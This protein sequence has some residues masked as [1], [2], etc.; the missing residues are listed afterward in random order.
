MPFF[1]DADPVGPKDSEPPDENMNVLEETILSTQDVPAPSGDLKADDDAGSS[2][3]SEHSPTVS[4]RMELIE[5]IKRGESPTWA[6]QGT[7]E[8]YYRDSPRPDKP[9]EAQE[10]SNETKTPPTDAGQQETMPPASPSEI[11][12]PRSAMH[13]GDFFTQQALPRQRPSC[14]T[15][16]SVE[17]NPPIRA[18]PEYPVWPTIPL[19]R[20]NFAQETPH[21]QEQSSRPDSSFP[22]ES[23]V[24]TSLECDQPATPLPFEASFLPVERSADHVP[25][26]HPPPP[27]TP[28]S[29]RRHTLPQQA[30][31]ALRS[32]PPAHLPTLAATEHQSPSLRAGNMP[33]QGHQARRSF[34]SHTP[35]FGQGTSPPFGSM[36]SRRPSLSSESPSLH[37]A[38][39]VGSY[40]ESIL[41]GRMSTA[42]SKPLDFV[43]Q[44]GVLGLGACPAHLRCPSHVSVPF[45]AVFYSYSSSASR[46]P[47]GVEEGPSPYVGLIDL[48]NSLDNRTG[49]QSERRKRHGLSSADTDASAS[50]QM[51]QDAGHLPTARSS[52]NEARRQRRK[53]RRSQSPK[54]PPGGSYRIPQK[55]QLQ[56]VLKNPNKTAVKLFLIPYD[57]DGMEPGT[58]TF[59]RQR[60]YS[61]GPVLE[62][63]LSSNNN[64]N[65]AVGLV[66]STGVAIDPLSERP[67]LRYLI[68]LHICSPSRGRFFL[69][70]SIRVVFAN[71][72]PDGKE[73]LRNEIQL[74]EPRYSPYKPGRESLGSTGPHVNAMSTVDRAFRRRSSGLRPGPAQY[75]AVDGIGTSSHHPPSFHPRYLHG[76]TQSAQ[77]SSPLRPKGENLE[78]G[79]EDPRVHSEGLHQH[80]VVDDRP[81]A[82][83]LFPSTTEH[84]YPAETMAEPPGLDSDTYAKLSR[85]D[86]GYGG[87]CGPTSG[88]AGD[89]GE[90][91]LARRL[92]GLD[93]QHP[94]DGRSPF[95]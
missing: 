84:Q 2:P 13:S 45:P 88:A 3:K 6:P 85:G 74:P 33:Y 73:H 49:A 55:G 16:G 80:W 61:T 72:V 67:T 38:S 28:Q 21:H 29:S 65:Q 56:I 8:D 11:E 47:S 43:A 53:K 95:D 83:Q 10:Q 63:P 48:E 54:S 14:L 41:R 23:Q 70:K 4:D 89:T 19:D 36:R 30:L 18:P 15:S 32:A 39:M 12:R 92:R 37:L 78:Q 79:F 82:R 94:E 26:S 66:G 7:L 93:V 42:P 87:Y 31:L 90:S 58:K 75:D 35:G 40:E 44:I 51:G 68:H 59:I 27:S 77:F 20:A 76:R 91:L 17:T 57:L 62:L 71:R 9:V 5:R 50:S 1:H 34:T 24:P 22:L 81:A 86:R 25:T 69:Y 64:N 46:A 60:C 52:D